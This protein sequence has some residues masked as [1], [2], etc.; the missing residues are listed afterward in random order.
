MT[1]REKIQKEYP[2]CV[3]E[4]FLGGCKGCPSIYGYKPAGSGCSPLGCAK[5]W[6]TVI[7]GTEEDE[8]YKNLTP[9]ELRT[10]IKLLEGRVETKNAVIENWKRGCEGK[11]REIQ[12]LRARCAG[13]KMMARSS[14]GIL[15]PSGCPGCNSKNGE[16]AQLALQV[17]LEKSEKGVLMDRI[18]DLTKK[19]EEEK[20]EHAKHHGLLGYFYVE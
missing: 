14:F 13:Y 18:K 5:C 10:V 4:K 3:N 20:K 9:D 15:S 19:L 6:D 7:P 1:Y 11:N 2:E 17:E 16:I 12:E 8:K